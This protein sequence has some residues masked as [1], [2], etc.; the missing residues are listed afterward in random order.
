MTPVDPEL[1]TEA[2]LPSPE[3]AAHLLGA[4]EREL[5]A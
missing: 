3:T 5:W 4:L 1:V 2:G